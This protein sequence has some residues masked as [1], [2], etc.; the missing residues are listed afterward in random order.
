M[1]FASQQLAVQTPPAFI[2]GY[3][4]GVHLSEATLDILDPHLHPKKQKNS[5]LWEAFLAFLM[6][7]EGC[8]LFPFNLLIHFFRNQGTLEN[9]P[10]NLRSKLRE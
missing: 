5:G 7:F 6:R 3:G 2:E 1:F 9:V 4:S 10:E 8:Q